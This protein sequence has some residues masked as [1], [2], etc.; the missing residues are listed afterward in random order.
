MK[1]FFV[2]A[3]IAAFGMGSILNIGVALLLALRSKSKGVD[4]LAYGAAMGILAHAFIGLVIALGIFPSR[5]V[6]GFA[7]IC[8]NIASL[9]YWIR[10]KRPDFFDLLA[11]KFSIIGIVGAF[12]AVVFS[13]FMAFLPVKMPDIL[14]DGPYVIK[15]NN[16]HVR[17]QHITGDLPAD[18]VIPHI[19]SEFFLRH[20]S[21][22]IERPVLPGQEVSNRP[23]LMSLVVLPFRDLIDPPEKQIERLARFSYVGTSWPDVAP[24]ADN[25]PF[26]QFLAIA[27]VLNAML[28]LSIAFVMSRFEF[29]VGVAVLAIGT[30]VASPYF[31]S[32]ILFTWPKALAGF[33]LLLSLCEI[34]GRKRAYV[35]GLLAAGAYWSHPY[36]IVFAFS[37]FV[38]LL[39]CDEKNYFTSRIIFSAKYIFA[40]VVAVLPWFVWTKGY[41]HIP[42]DLVSQNLSTGETLLNIIW[43]RFYNIY[44]LLTPGVFGV[45]PFNSQSAF[46]SLIITLPGLVGLAFFIP[47]YVGIVSRYPDRVFISGFYVTLP[48]LL[49]TFVF[50]SPAVPALHG[51]QAIAPMVFILGL[52]WMHRIQ[53]SNLI[54]CALL[55]LQIFMNLGVWAMRIYSLI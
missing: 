37:F 40:W 14:I 9:I 45:Y 12:S 1:L 27:V 42:S 29:S 39:F 30:F 44:Q 38:Y 26:I 3:S 5:W 24:L 11:D 54:I 6:G 8:G 15:N 51:F 19:V 43:V 22:K 52:H 13:L 32:Q 20:I 16:I 18:N 10:Y 47:G 4:A 46:N 34:L 21:F 2:A 25:R 23:V 50:S 55:C 33:F 53:V 28:V 48:A 7:L 36:A 49:L 35:I 31:L 41:L 17:I